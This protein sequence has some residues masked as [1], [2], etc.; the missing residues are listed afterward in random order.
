MI[1]FAARRATWRRRF[2]ACFDMECEA[3]RRVRDDMG[4]KEPRDHDPVR[5]HAAGGREVIRLL[6]ENGLK[7]RQGRPAR[8]H[9]VR[10]CRR[11][12]CSPT[13]SSNTS[14]AFR[15]VRTT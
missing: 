4:L 11:T 2:R 8:D 9:D 15:S 14:T 7:A 5:T 6:G 1:G 13:S 10:G 3:I 12:P